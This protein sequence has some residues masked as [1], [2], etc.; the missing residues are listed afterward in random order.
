MIIT[1]P[2]KYFQHTQRSVFL[3]GTI[4]NGASL[5]WQD[6][7]AKRLASAFPDLVIYNPRR[8]IWDINASNADLVSQIQW[9]LNYLQLSDIVFFNFLEDS[10]SPVTMLELGLVL[11]E[12]KDCVIVNPKKFYRHEN[13][14]ITAL[15]YNSTPYYTYE[16]G[17][18]KLVDK[19]NNAI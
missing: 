4:D 11:A 16:I 12:R 10:K 13:V 3:A 17:Y 5:D 2:E 7:T 18:S 15:R 9:E 14:L 19:L 8:K 1:A 6:E